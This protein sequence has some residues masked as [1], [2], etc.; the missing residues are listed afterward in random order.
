LCFSAAD[1]DSASLALFAAGWLAGPAEKKIETC[2]EHAERK[3][4]GA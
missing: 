1:G 4:I 2:D 3:K